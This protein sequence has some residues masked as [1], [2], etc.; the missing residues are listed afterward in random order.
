M[1]LK[2]L[3]LEYPALDAPAKVLDGVP[4]PPPAAAAPSTRLQTQYTPRSSR[5]RG[6]PSRHTR[7]TARRPHPPRPRDLRIR[8]WTPG[9][10]RRRVCRWRGP[11]SE[12]GAKTRETPSGW[13]SAGWKTRAASSRRDGARGVVSARGTE[14]GETH[15][16]EHSLASF[17]RFSHTLRAV[18]SAQRSTATRASPYASSNASSAFSAAVPTPC[19]AVDSRACSSSKSVRGT[20]PETLRS[21]PRLSRRACPNARLSRRRVRLRGRPRLR[22]R[23]R[24]LGMT[25]GES[26]KRGE[27]QRYTGR[28]HASVHSR[29]DLSLRARGER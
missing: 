24:R 22:R 6:R 4:P 26:S 20:S 27:R 7:H 21:E 29:D 8:A 12:T 17:H 14:S 23:P 9:I 15:L 1:A 2:W 3:T 10:P 25:S 11:D 18:A 13:N 28:A 5:G 16:A 19:S